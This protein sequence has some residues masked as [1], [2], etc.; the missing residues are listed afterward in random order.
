MAGGQR[1]VVQCIANGPCKCFKSTSIICLT[2]SSASPL[3]Q[4]STLSPHT[5]H[6]S[7][8][9]SP[10]PPTAENE[11][12][13]RFALDRWGMAAGADGCQLQLL[14]AT[15]LVGGPGLTGPWVACSG[16]TQVVKV[17][18]K[19]GASG[20]TGATG[21]AV[22]GSETTSVPASALNTT[23]ASASASDTIPASETTSASLG[24]LG[25]GF[26]ALNSHGWLTAQEAA[27]VQRFDPDDAQGNDSIGFF[28]AK[29]RKGGSWRG[30]VPA[31][32]V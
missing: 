18:G 19:T 32:E 12:N 10:A 28:V 21:A 9:L 8:T 5:P 16:N 31:G 1:L 2:R 3:S 11:G 25:A 30:G 15:P 23:L 29:F 14:P 17:R 4:N 26:D 13:V 20:G 7:P 6:P 24:A 22:Q 27:M